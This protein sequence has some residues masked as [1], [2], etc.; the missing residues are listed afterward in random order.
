MSEADGEVGGPA[1]PVIP[2]LFF[3]IWLGS[4][5]LPADFVTFGRNWMRLHPG[6]SMVHLTSPDDL[7]DFPNK[8]LL[9][10]CKNYAQMSDILRYEALWQLGGVYLDTD[11]DCQK[12]IE[13]LLTGDFVGAGERPDMVSAGFIAA[14]P[15]HPLVGRVR[16]LLPERI[17]RPGRQA[18]TTGPGL[19]TE[20]WQEFKHDPSVVTYGPELFYP[21]HWTEQ[22]RRHEAFPGAYAIH[23]W[24]GSWL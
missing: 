15:Q 24:A 10:E 18:H 3:R 4:L 8:Q 9:G 23:H 7:G 21:Y 5:S 2:Q 1:R 14:R 17:K 13:E 19:L 22:H 20:V 6:W 11:F 16:E 12:N